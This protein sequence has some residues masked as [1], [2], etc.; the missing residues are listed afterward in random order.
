[1]IIEILE[2]PTEKTWMN[3]KERALITCGKTPMTPPTSN[4]IHR[5][6]EARH[7]PIRY[8]RYSFRFEG[9]PSWVAT[10]FARHVHAQPYIKSQRNDRQN[11]YDR[12]AA[13]QDAPVNM[14]L[15]MNAEEL[16][17]MA[18]KRLCMQ[19]A[20]ETRK[21]MKIM[22][23]LAVEKTPELAGLLVPMC[24][25]NGFTCHEMK[26]CGRWKAENK[27]DETAG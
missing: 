12:N 10:H 18:N 21:I 15:D 9:I 22:C 25:Y 17:I 26:P 6:L 16:M 7:S 23:G 11:E 1:M 2:W 14:I 27:E 8:A 19:A 5:I 4:W 13:R 24:E 20:E 3:V